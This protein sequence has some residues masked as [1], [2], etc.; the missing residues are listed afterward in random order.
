MGE[1]RTLW[2]PLL[3]PAALS[4]VLPGI[5]VLVLPL[6]VSNPVLRLWLLSGL[7][8]GG[9]LICA[10]VVV[11]GFWLQRRCH[12]LNRHLDDVLHNV[13]GD[14]AVNICQQAEQ[15]AQLDAILRQV[16]DGVLL[17][18]AEGRCLR[19]NPTADR[20]LGHAGQIEPGQSLYT[21]LARGPLS[22]TLE[23]LRC[24][25]DTPDGDVSAAADFVCAT[26]SDKLLHCRMSL[27]PPVGT[28][29]GAFVLTF[30]DM[31]ARLKQDIAQRAGSGT[32][33]EDL[34]RALANLRAAAE[35][36]ARSAE[37][38]VGQRQLFQDVI[39]D[40]GEKLDRRLDT[41]ARDYRALF[42][43]QWPLSDVLST[44]LLH[45]V[46]RHMA[47]RRG[48]QVRIVERPLWLHVDS[49]A[50]LLLLESLLDRLQDNEIGTAFDIEC[51]SGTRQVYVDIVWQGR[52]L[53][54]A[55]VDAWLEQSLGE[56]VGARTGQE[57]LRRHNSDLWS[58]PHRLPGRSLL[59]LPLPAARQ[60]RGS[61]QENVS[62]RPAV[63]ETA[64]TGTTNALGLLA[65]RH[66]SQLT[67]VVF[68]L[69]TTGADPVQGD[70]IIRIAGVRVVQG[71]IL[72]GETFVQW[73][74]PDRPLSATM[75]CLH[76]ITDESLREALPIEQALVQFKAFIGAGETVLASHNALLGMKFLHCKEAVAGLR[77]DNPVLDTLLLSGFLHNHN[78][79]HT[80]AAIA[81]LLGVEFQDSHD[82]LATARVTAEVFIKLLNLL[83]VNGMKT[84]RQA[85]EA[86]EKLVGI[87][88]P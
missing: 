78:G 11:A 40:E 83:E 23:L 57:V 74:K 24:R 49:H 8:L 34:R 18:D 61:E 53:A 63:S 41:L 60:E 35:S 85:F 44:D 71:E 48:L 33:L 12:T 30:N 84:L 73:V 77:F 58:Q 7:L 2:L 54:P 3:L 16:S 50:V 87:R 19:H 64:P 32:S 22:T 10:T 4:L 43:T 21:L 37:M 82:A 72:I 66:L 25:T 45:C 14:A 69:A 67:Y 51:L 68:D 81:E 39:N 6:F 27:L 80:L 65:D 47:D 59:R 88:R 5:A 56:V 13:A 55:T 17:C 28:L 75:T 70:E 1:R 15:A 26:V 20:V 38:E 46:A 9:L 31:T 36:M 79:E 76:S 52:P 42:E 29:K 86:S 62:E